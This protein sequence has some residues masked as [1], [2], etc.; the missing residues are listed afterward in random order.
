MR[1]ALSASLLMT[2][3]TLLINDDKTLSW[4]DD[5]PQDAWVFSGA[6]KPGKCFDTLLK[7]NHLSVDATIDSRYESVARTVLSGSMFATPPYAL[8]MSQG[9]I[10]E[11]IRKIVHQ[12]VGYLG[13]IDTNY[14]DSTWVPAT[15]VFDRL[16]PAKI[17]TTSWHGWMLREVGNKPIIKT[18]APGTDDFA[19]PVEYDRF[20]TRTGRLTVK[21]GPNILTL[22][23][24]ARNMITSRYQNGS[25]IFYDF[26][27][28][29]ARVV[30]YEAGRRC[31]E[32]DLYGMMTR[33]LFDNQIE[34]NVVKQAVLSELYGQGHAALGKRLGIAGEALTA[35][36]KRIRTYFHFGKLQRHVK[37][38]FIANGYVTNRFGRKITIDEPLDNIIFN[39]YVQSTA[40]DVALLGFDCLCESVL[41][42]YTNFTPLFLLHDALIIDVEDASKL[43]EVAWIKVPGYVQ[44]WPVKLEHMTKVEVQSGEEEQE[45]E[46]TRSAT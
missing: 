23:K 19:E 21:S 5:I 1:V 28:Q 20:G 24:D 27:G 37:G 2:D 25:I 18:F 16:R 42:Q 7:L 14:F 26:S 35:F 30:L 46:I 22:R 39:S 9:H 34:R 33:Q 15:R 6:P 10:K 36:I 43:P 29:E 13:S 44:R 3:K 32:L 45:D 11:R 4:V 17:D 38:G 40:A 41:P 12:V 31:E 8:L